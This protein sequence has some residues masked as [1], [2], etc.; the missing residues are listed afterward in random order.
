[1][2]RIGVMDL[3]KVDL[4]LLVVFDAV[5]RER[6]V[7]RA[8]QRLGLSQPAVSAAL[9]RLREIFG[10]P[11]FIRTSTG[12]TPT[13]RAQQ[14]VEPVGTALLLIRDAL[15]EQ[16]RFDPLKS[17]REFNLFTMDIGEARFLP[18]LVRHLHGIGSSMCVTATTLSKDPVAGFETGAIDL[19]LGYWPSFSRRLGFRQERLF[20]DTFV[21]I[22]RADH[23]GL[24]E[25]LTIEDYVRHPHVVVAAQGKTDG[26]IERALSHHGLTRRIAARV[27]HYLSAPAIVAQSDLIATMP[28]NILGELGL[29]GSLRIMTLPFRVS[30]FP[31]TLYWHRRAQKDAAL[32]WMCALICRLFQQQEPATDAKPALS[33]LALE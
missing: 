6:N 15:E 22:C 20:D 30:T 12:V 2:M 33:A 21:C 5:I 26:P 31:V 13:Q 1:M 11:L 14:L 10:D 32:Q 27:P 9:A 7:T 17:R 8:G 18:K 29:T 28:A 25:P 4:N 3:G 19:A 24:G 16:C 23:P